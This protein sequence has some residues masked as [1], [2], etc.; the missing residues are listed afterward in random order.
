MKKVKQRKINYKNTLNLI[1]LNIFHINNEGK[2][3]T[4]ARITNSFC[5]NAP[6]LAMCS[7][8]NENA[9]LRL[10]RDGENPELFA[11]QKTEFGWSISL[12][13]ANSGLY[14]YSF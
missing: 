13:I 11:M 2:S 3:N 10:F 5:E 9:Y 6:N 12:K 8:P 4:Q 7:L 1:Q 14:F